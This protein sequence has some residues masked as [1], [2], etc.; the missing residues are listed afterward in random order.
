MYLPTS[1]QLKLNIYYYYGILIAY[2]IVFHTVNLLKQLNTTCQVFFEL[3]PQ[4]IN[5]TYERLYIFY[6]KNFLVK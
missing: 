5:N 2:C 3:F 1:T 6:E 4:N